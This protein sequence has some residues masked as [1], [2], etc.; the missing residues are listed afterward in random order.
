MTLTWPTTD[1]ALLAWS[2]LL[3]AWVVA[4]YYVGRTESVWGRVHLTPSPSWWTPAWPRMVL[5]VLAPFIVLQ[6]QAV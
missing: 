6:R 4:L 2:Q 1:S 3:F 5:L